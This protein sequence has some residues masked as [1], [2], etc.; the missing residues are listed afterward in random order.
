MAR[1]VGIVECDCLADVVNAADRM[2]K[3]ASV[4]LVRREYL[5]EGRVS[6]VVDGD[7]DEVERALE[8]AKTGAPASLTVT[9]VPNVDNRVLSLF[10][11]PGGRWWH[12]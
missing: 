5:G 6:L 1:S 7:T 11:L 12:A 4:R 2:V 9:L 10:D 8:A 3:S